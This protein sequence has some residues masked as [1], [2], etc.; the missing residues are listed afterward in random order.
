MKSGGGRVWVCQLKS[1]TNRSHGELSFSHNL[2]FLSFPLER[3][4]HWNLGGASPWISVIDPCID[5]SLEELQHPGYPWKKE[6]FNQLWLVQLV[7]SR[8]RQRFCVEF[9]NWINLF[10]EFFQEFLF[11]HKAKLI[12]RSWIKTKGDMFFP[13]LYISFCTNCPI[14]H[15]YGFLSF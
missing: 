4:P 1:K 2:P 9:K 11:Y 10:I 13:G 6:F 3:G 12:S 7:G 5:I 14:F 15:H 8:H